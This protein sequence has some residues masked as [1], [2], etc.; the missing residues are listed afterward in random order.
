MSGKTNHMGL[1]IQLPDDLATEL[2]REAERLGVEPQRYAVQIIQQ[3]L[4]AAERA[5]SL[6]DLFAR[7]AAE[8]ATDDPQEL[9]RRQQEWEQLKRAL[10]A[11][12]ASGRKL[13][14]E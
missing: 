7:W 3:H 4:P 5:K 6:H 12:R 1:T 9:A 14:G 13:F 10:D 2:R 8:D 11:N